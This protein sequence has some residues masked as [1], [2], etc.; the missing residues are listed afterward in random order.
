MAALKRLRQRAKRKP[1]DAERLSL[2]PLTFE[3]AVKGA[4]GVK[5]DQDEEGDDGARP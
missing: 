2:A 1:K 3:Q 5:T 4:L